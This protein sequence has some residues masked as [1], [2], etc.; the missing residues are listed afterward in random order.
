MTS[1]KNWDDQPRGTRRWCG[2]GHLCRYRR[3]NPSTRSAPDGTDLV[4]HGIGEGIPVVCLPGG[5]TRDSAYLGQVGGHIRK[6]IMVDS[7]GVG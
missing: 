4:Y 1:D 7:R 6:L 3:P 2:C 5:P